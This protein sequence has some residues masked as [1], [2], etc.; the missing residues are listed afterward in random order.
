MFKV[1][2]VNIC[3]FR[4]LNAALLTNAVLGVAVEMVH[5]VTLVQC[6]VRQMGA[7]ARTHL[8]FVVEMVAVQGHL[9]AA[10]LGKYK[11]I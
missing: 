3:V 11:F 8:H 1:V 6:A 2:K 4:D 5:V 10:H 7:A 9:N